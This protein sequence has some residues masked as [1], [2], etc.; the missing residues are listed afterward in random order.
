MIYKATV[1]AFDVEVLQGGTAAEVI[2]W[3]DANGYAQNPAAE[4]ILQ[5]YLAPAKPYMFAAIK[6]TGNA[7]VDEIHPLVL[8]Y[9]GDVPCV[10]LKLTAVAA[11]ED[12]GVRTFFL[13]DSRAVSTNYKNIELNPAQLNWR[14]LSL[15]Y[16]DVVSQAVDSPVANGQ[17]FVTEYAGA[18]NVVGT[19]N[20]YYPTWNSSAFVSV[21]PDQ[22]IA[23]MIGQNL[24]QCYSYVN[25]TPTGCVFQIFLILPLLHDYLPPP[26]GV[27]DADFYG[28][29][30]TACTQT[31]ANCTQ[32][33]ASQVDPQAWNGLQFAQDLESRVVAPGKRAVQLLQTNPYLTRLYTTISPA[34][35]TLDPNNSSCAQV[36]PK[37]GNFDTATLRYTCNNRQVMNGP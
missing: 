1:G 31:N 15:N 9:T 5:E 29:L 20:I 8:R 3:L 37:C 16:N 14:N 12:M 17:A 35:M 7:G 2:D 13:G 24:A 18:S 11:K 30:D 4:P 26:A 6:L 27:T 21:A 36:C 33:Y 19:N 10:P 34:E 32:C 22:V 25:G 23:T 28:C